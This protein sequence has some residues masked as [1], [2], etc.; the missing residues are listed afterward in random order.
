MNS[1]KPQGGATPDRRDGDKAQDAS[2]EDE[3]ISPQ[4][5]AVIGCGVVAASVVVGVLVVLAVVLVVTTGR[6]AG[7]ASPK[8]E[9]VLTV[10]NECPTAARVGW[11]LSDSAV[12]L[13]ATDSTRFFPPPEAGARVSDTLPA[14]QT[15]AIEPGESGKVAIGRASIGSQERLLLVEASAGPTKAVTAYSYKPDRDTPLAA[16][17]RGESPSEAG[18]G[19]ALTLNGESCAPQGLHMVALR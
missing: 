9:V 16:S 2:S 11:V 15:G 7:P 19:P 5:A 4:R 3:P 6:D 17:S 13:T 1:K 8:A 10:K 14:N 18:D 12:P